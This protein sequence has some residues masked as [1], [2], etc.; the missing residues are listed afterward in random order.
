MIVKDLQRLPRFLISLIFLIGLTITVF[1]GSGIV[2]LMD[3]GFQQM[4]QGTVTTVETQL[5]TIIS[6]V[7]S[8]TMSI[9]YTLI[10]ALILWVIRYRIAAIWALCTLIGG[11]VIAKLMKDFVHRARPVDHLAVDDGFSFPSG[12]VFGF[13]I[14]V[15]LIWILVMP[16]IQNQ[17]IGAIIRIVTIVLLLL[18]VI[19]RIYLSAHFPTDTFGAMLLAYTW[20]QVAEWLAIGLIPILQKWPLLKDSKVA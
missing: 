4:I 5:M 3:S 15:A 14:V 7:S 17:L 19:A 11:D 20:L 18:V 2:T 10:L 16:L 1:R 9:V 12:H 6:A 13:F 8:P